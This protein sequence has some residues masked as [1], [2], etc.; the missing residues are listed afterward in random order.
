MEKPKKSRQ[1]IFESLWIP[2]ETRRPPKEDIAILMR[3]EAGLFGITSGVVLNAQQDQVESGIC[4]TDQ[5]M[6]FLKHTGYFCKFWMR[7]Y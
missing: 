5:K 3:T 7:L 2:I 6:A 4:L 1:A